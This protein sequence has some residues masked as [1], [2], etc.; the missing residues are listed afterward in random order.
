[1]L[2]LAR[3]TV[4]GDGGR[5]QNFGVVRPDVPFRV[6]RTGMPIAVEI[7]RT[8]RH[9]DMLALDEL[10]SGG[11]LSF[12]LSVFGDG[13][14]SGASSERL[15]VQ[16]SLAAK[17]SRSDWVALLKAAGAE[18]IVL[19][20]VP[21]PFWPQSD[22]W[23]EVQAMVV[24]G[25]SL[26]LEAH[27]DESVLA[28]RKALEATGRVLGWSEKWA[29]EALDRAAKDRRAMTKLEREQLMLGALHHFANLSAHPGDTYDRDE[30]RMILIETL[31]A[32]GRLTRQAMRGI[33]S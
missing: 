24:R 28:C 11:N 33:S 26:F 10:R 14:T 1:M 2:V 29:A 31:G 7:R 18:N 4:T 5:Q 16:V 21:M 17:A 19:F 20:E 15:P 12:G 8:L 27:Y 32:L 30:A 6:R 23:R 22:D 25:Q 9:A 13:S 3:L